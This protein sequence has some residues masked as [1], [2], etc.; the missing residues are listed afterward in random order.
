MNFW[1]L[2][3]HVLG[4]CVW[5][6]GHLYLV[7]TILPKALR[8]QNAQLIL[9]FEGGF[10][11]MGMTALVVQITTGLYMAHLFLPKLSMLADHRN[12]IAVLVSLKLTWLV[13]T[14]V[15]ALSVQLR[16]IPKLKQDIN[17][18]R[19]RRSFIRHIL[20]VTTLALAFV[21]TGVMFR[22]GLPIDLG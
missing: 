17:N 5:V 11:K 7:V 20:I 8:E 9:D 2:L 22:T 3:L 16:V 13:L 4:A 18:A 1:V 14:A 19:L 12:P 21:V 15:T 6:G 10:E